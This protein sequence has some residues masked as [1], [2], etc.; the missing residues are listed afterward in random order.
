MQ[1]QIFLP[2]KKK[3]FLPKN[4]FCRSA[5]GSYLNANLFAHNVLINAILK[6]KESN[7][8]HKITSEGKN[9]ILY[10]IHTPV[11]Q[12]RKF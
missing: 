4:P 1:R 10:T 8:G 6:E 7:G 12:T 5:N 11:P 2:K 3:S 9:V